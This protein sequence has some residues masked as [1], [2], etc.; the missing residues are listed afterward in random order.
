MKKKD[1]KQE[2]TVLAGRGFEG[3]KIFKCMETRK[4]GPGATGKTPRKKSRLKKPKRIG[5]GVLTYEKVLPHILRIK[6][7]MD[8]E[9][10][11]RG[12]QSLKK[13]ILSSRGGFN[14]AVYP[15]QSLTRLERCG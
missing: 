11:G 15:S 13:L 5:F 2:E 4:S 14:E 3:R 7:E 8:D 10:W 6:K 1:W 12:Q 9:Q